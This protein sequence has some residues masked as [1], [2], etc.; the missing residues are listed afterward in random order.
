MGQMG[1]IVPMPPPAGDTDSAV[2]Y[3]LLR[4]LLGDQLREARHER[5]ERLVDVAE[6]AG[7]SPQYLSEVERGMKDP[8]S[9]VVAAITGALQMPLRELT[10]RVVVR[11]DSVPVGAGRS[12][13][14][15][16]MGPRSAG[17]RSTGPVCLA[18]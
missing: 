7:V 17:S 6:R 14:P 12:M 4:E 18:A 11:L 10:L 1:Q 5:G 9:E 2:A 3:P 8:S 16:S 13:G 15:R